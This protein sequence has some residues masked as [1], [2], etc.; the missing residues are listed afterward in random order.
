MNN[1]DTLQNSHAPQDTQRGSALIVA[2]FL[3]IFAVGIV[4]SGS[5]T[6]H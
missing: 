2:M 3:M 4:M 1:Q 6:M 5:I